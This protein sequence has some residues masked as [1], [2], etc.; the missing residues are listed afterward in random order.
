MGSPRTEKSHD[1]DEEQV[2]VTLTKPFFLGRTEVTQGQW[3]TVM[4]TTPWKGTEYGREQDNCAATHI[5]WEDAQAFCKKL[6]EQLGEAYR[7]PTEAE[8]EFAC[9]AGTATRHS[10]GDTETSLREYAWYGGLEFEGNARRE[11]YAHDVATRKPNAFGLFD[12]H[13][14]VWEWCEDAYDVK[15]PGGTDPVRAGKTSVRVFRGGSWTRSISN[16]RSASR[17]WYTPSP[18]C[19]DIGFRVARDTSRK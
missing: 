15:L 18:R 3:R 16:S 2:D 1:D 6:S 14:N 4:G 12:M 7:L 17:E 11:R 8:W 19:F 9:R 5:G 13:G 10:F